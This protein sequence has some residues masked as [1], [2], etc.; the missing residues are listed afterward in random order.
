MPGDD[1]IKVLI[2]ALIGSLV[3]ASP[4]RSEDSCLLRA[5]NFNLQPNEHFAGMFR[6]ALN[7]PDLRDSVAVQ[8]HVALSETWADTISR[9]IS[10]KTGGLCSALIL[11]EGFPGLRVTLTVN[12]TA[13]QIDR[14]KSFCAH[15][16]E[17]ILKHFQPTDQLIKQAVKRGALFIQ[18]SQPAPGVAAV[19]LLGDEANISQAALPLIYEK[20]SLLH[21]LASV[22][23]ATYAAVEAADLRTWIQG[24]RSPERPLLESIPHC[25]PPRGDLASSPGIPR[26]RSDSPILPPGEID[27]LRSQNGPLPMGPLRHVVVVGDPAEPPSLAVASEVKTKYCN[28][29]HTFSIGGDSS[30]RASATVRPRCD[31]IGVYDLDAWNIIYCDPK[32]CASENLEK[33]V[34]AAIAS[35]PEVLDFARRSSDTAIPRGPYLINIK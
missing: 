7:P 15:A 8:R 11:P 20:G 2:L 28:R 19:D 21:A 14:E 27:L 12:L 6:I 33:A 24:Q 32:D 13:N 16:L 31:T 1:W 4:S 30:P 35:D 17:D 9:E 5:G 18:P 29:E 25:L 10:T 34:M 26:E 22:E 3:I 23:S